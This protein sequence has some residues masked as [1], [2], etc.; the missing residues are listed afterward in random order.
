MQFK[1]KI[2]L[3]FFFFFLT[4]QICLTFVWRSK[5]MTSD[6]VFVIMQMSGQGFAFT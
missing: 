2:P 5:G 1:A 6:K 3:A 4:G